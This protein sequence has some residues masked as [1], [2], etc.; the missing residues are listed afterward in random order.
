MKLQ[1]ELYPILA[2]ALASQRTAGCGDPQAPGAAPRDSTDLPDPPEIILGS[3]MVSG[4]S[5]DI[6]R[7][8]SDGTTRGIIVS[9]GSAPAWR[10]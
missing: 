7:I 8:R 9:Q 3:P 2:P 4:S 5:G 6:G 10:P 1:S